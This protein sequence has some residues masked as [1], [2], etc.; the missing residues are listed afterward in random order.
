MTLKQRINLK[1]AQ[2][3]V[4][5][6]KMRQALYIL[7]LPLLE[8]KRFLQEKMIENPLLEEADEYQ[9]K[10]DLQSEELI[11][12][13]L[14]NEKNL[15][16]FFD[17]DN[18]NTS[19]GQ[20]IQKKQTFKETLVTSTP[21]LQEHLLR[22][23]SVSGC[24]P[25]I[26]KSGTFIIGNIDENGY[27][28]CSPKEMHEILDTSRMDIRRALNLIHTFD[29]PGVG[30][31]DLKEC[32]LIQLRQK[33]KEHSLAA[34]IVR[35]YLTDLEKKKYDHLARVFKETPAKIEE[36]VREVAFLEPKPGRSFSSSPDSYIRPDIILQKQKEKYEVLLNDEELPTL[37]ISSQ[38]RELLRDEKVA[39]NTK[40][41]LKEQLN[42]AI[43]LIKAVAQR[44]STLL[45][46][47]RFLVEAQ[48]DFL[49]KG[50]RY[51]LPLTVEEIAKSI[52]RNKSTVS[53]VIANKYMQTPYGIFALREF[54][55]QAIKMKKGGFISSK[56]IKVQIEELIKAENLQHPLTDEKIVE[57]LEK[58]QIHIARR[59]CAKYREQLKI[60]PASLRKK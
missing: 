21:S 29:P 52:K 5:T 15:P 35:S 7:Q 31:Q 58:K 19:Y 14:Q 45:K 10:E 40:R 18:D 8:L 48:K 34:K 50:K 47:A 51:L 53:R 1:F 28:H 2:R 33:N 24:A 12:N 3:L 60:L 26:Y 25:S 56:N 37:Q 44:Q 13:V 41:Y 59:T 32:L 23:L 49:D 22:Q 17:T 20:E 38:Y 43:W 54:L 42:S 6:P 9:V 57:I 36:A 46:L 30:A 16:E 39:K 4:L 11:D 55:S 27:L